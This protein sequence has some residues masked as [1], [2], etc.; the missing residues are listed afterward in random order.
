MRLLLTLCAF[1]LVLF[2]SAQAQAQMVCPAGAHS[3]GPGR[4]CCPAGSKC[5]PGNG[6]SVRPGDRLGI[7][8][9]ALR[10]RVGEYC[11]TQD[12]QKRCRVR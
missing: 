8:C 2:L 10:C 11:I 3:C 7:R 9:G 5:L 1:T 6:C 4:G 12:G